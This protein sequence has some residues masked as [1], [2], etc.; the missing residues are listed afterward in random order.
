L[1]LSVGYFDLEDSGAY[2]VACESLGFG[3]CM[4]ARRQ[5]RRIDGRKNR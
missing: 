1:V 3:W 4:T 5:R 2:H